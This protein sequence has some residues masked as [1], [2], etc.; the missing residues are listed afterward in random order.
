[1]VRVDY[2]IQ[3]TVGKRGLKDY[4]QYGKLVNG[5]CGSFQSLLKVC[6]QAFL[7]LDCEFFNTQVFVS[8]LVP[9]LVVDELL[10]VPKNCRY[11]LARAYSTFMDFQHPDPVQV[12]TEDIGQSVWQVVVQANDYRFNA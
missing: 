1:M 9:G 2:S 10:V 4:T 12:R 5:I 7:Y 3:Y 8:L 6:P 11:D